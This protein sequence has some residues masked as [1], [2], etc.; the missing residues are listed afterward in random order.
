MFD[1]IPKL[2]SSVASFLFP[3]FASYKALKTSD[4]AQLTPW[5]MYWSVLSCALL[6]ESWTEFILVWVPFYSYMRL[7]FLLYLV[8]PQ[9][10]GARV[11]YETYL[12]PYLEDNESVIEDF[13]AS[14]HDRLKAAGM[15]YLKRAIEMLR[16]QVLGMPPREE[17]QQREEERAAAAPQGYTQAL[18][19]RF[20]VP[21]SRWAANNAGTAGSDF[22]NL[23]AGAVGAA[24]GGF[25]PPSK[26]QASS[27]ATLIPENISGADEKINFIAAQKERLAFMMGALDKEAKQLERSEEERK[28]AEQAR[29]DLRPGSMSLDG[30]E[31]SSRPPSGHSVL[32]GLSKS[33]SEVD[34][35]KIDAES[36]AEDEDG[37]LRRRT[38]AEPSP[39]SAKSGWSFLG[40]GSVGTS[41]PSDTGHSSG[42]QK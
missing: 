14:A 2:L 31:G 13:I 18:L 23:L 34:F 17:E 33:R 10:Q 37:N 39:G 8:L 6:V 25:A 35:E 22:Y 11:L 4:P 5:L 42:V 29:K 24:A 15:A 16:T 28:A 40:W 30:H 36:G 19:A 21:A 3:L 1:L 7:F 12:H 27:T 9:T 32:S 20:S 26:D 41:G 38:L